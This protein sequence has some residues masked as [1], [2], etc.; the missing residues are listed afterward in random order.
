MILILILI[1]KMILILI[2]PDFSRIFRIFE[3]YRSLGIVKN[4]LLGISNLCKWIE[5]AEICP[6]TQTYDHFIALRRGILHDSNFDFI[7]D[8]DFDFI[9]DFDFASKFQN[10]FDFDFQND[11]DFDFAPNFQNDF[12]FINDF[13]FDFA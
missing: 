5:L 12:D 3:N 11:F 7:N 8:F 1:F 4:Y 6:K 9:N 2:L 10:D 13:D